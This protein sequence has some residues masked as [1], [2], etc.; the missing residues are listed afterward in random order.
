M[1]S[2]FLDKPCSGNINLHRNQNWSD[3]KDATDIFIDLRV[4]IFKDN[5]IDAFDFDCF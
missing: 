2:H 5:S 1:D 4:N 3:Q